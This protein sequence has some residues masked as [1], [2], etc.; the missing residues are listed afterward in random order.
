MNLRFAVPPKPKPPVPLF[1]TIPKS[2]RFYKSHSTTSPEAGLID[3]NDNN[4]TVKTASM[5]NQQ[6]V[7]DKSPSPPTTL[8]TKSSSSKQNSSKHDPLNFRSLKLKPKRNLLKSLKKESIFG[9]ESSSNT[10][11][12]HSTRTEFLEA[13]KLMQ[14][15]SFSTEFL[16][17][18]NPNSP[19][20]EFYNIPKNN[21]ALGNNNADDDDD[22]RSYYVA[23]DN[24]LRGPPKL[25]LNRKT[26]IL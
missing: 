12:R 3:T 19:S 8:N 7:W 5:I 14:N 18:T 13:Q 10:S 4:L 11:K 24:V 1:S 23:S 25:H 26:C 20:E 2:K 6:G 16:A 17:L 15:I 9:K 21:C 22:T